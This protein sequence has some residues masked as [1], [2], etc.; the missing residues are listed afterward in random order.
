MSHI[1]AAV[2]GYSWRRVGAMVLRHVYLMRGSWFRVAEMAYWPTVQMIMWGFISQFFRTHSTWVAQAAGVLL[3]G[4]LL[5][6]VVFRGNLG[7][8]LSFMEEMWSRNL[9]NLFVTP[10]RPWELVVSLAVMSF[11]RTVIG[12]TPAALLAIVFYQF[13]IFSLGL[14]LVAFFFNLLMT[15]WCIGLA[16]SA[17]VL[18]FGLGAESMAWV[19]VFALA[20]LVGIYYP[21]DSLPVWLQPLAWATPPAH[22]FEGMRAIMFDGTVRLDHMAAAAGLNLFYLLTASLMFLK[23][24]GIARQRGLLM[25]V[26]E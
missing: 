4:V 2:R 9:A 23:V 18:R 13:N 15:G 22:V 6:D 5:W 1:A 24:F 17:L 16:V 25:N 20:P 26:G 21:I 10:L 11:I 12:V 3:G 19:L 8:S 7:L 14:P